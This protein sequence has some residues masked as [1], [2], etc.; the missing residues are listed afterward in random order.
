MKVPSRPAERRILSQFLIALVRLSSAWRRVPCSEGLG[1]T[2][3]LSAVILGAVE[4]RPFKSLKLAKYLN[5]PRTT[6]LRR[7]Q[8][9]IE[10]GF[11]EVSPDGFYWPGPKILSAESD[12]ILDTLE[13]MIFATAEGLRASRGDGGKYAKDVSEMDT[14]ALDAES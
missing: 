8:V 12:I 6:L 13:E 9:M 3:I 7:I 5:I 4:G 10:D 2:M 11:V 14:K 1:S